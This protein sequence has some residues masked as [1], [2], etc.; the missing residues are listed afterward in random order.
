M[1][2]R[3]TTRENWRTAC[4]MCKWSHR[5]RILFVWLLLLN[6]MFTDSPIMLHVAGFSAYRLNV[7]KHHNSPVLLS[8]CPVSSC[9]EYVARG[10]L[11]RLLLHNCLHSYWAHTRSRTGGHG[12]HTNSAL[13]CQTASPSG[14][15]DPLSHQHCVIV[16]V[17][18]HPLQF[19]A[20]GVFC[21]I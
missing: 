14:C 17:P 15:T 13:S 6:I 1:Q 3:H 5:A 8:W 21:V 16:L 11:L 19:C 10:I 7:R 12:A 20:I 18:L 9:Y 2:E 4:Q